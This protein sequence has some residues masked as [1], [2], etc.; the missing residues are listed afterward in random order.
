M[1]PSLAGW[2]ACP[3]VLAYGS[4]LFPMI[5]RMWD[6]RD[7]CLIS[8]PKRARGGGRWPGKGLPCSRGHRGSTWR[9]HRV[10]GGLPHHPELELG[11]MKLGISCHRCLITKVKP[12]R[13]LV[14]DR[15]PRPP[16]PQAAASLVL[17]RPASESSTRLSSRP[18]LCDLRSRGEGDVA[19]GDHRCPGS[20]N[21]KATSGSNKGQVSRGDSSGASAWQASS[22]ARTSSAAS[23]LEAP[24]PQ[25]SVS[26]PGTPWEW[27]RWPRAFKLVADASPWPCSCFR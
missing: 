18:L 2:G 9:P 25:A 20:L 5:P 27:L 1:I 8:S 4:Q 19:I 16:G 15:I 7:S 6:V 10:P 26:P 23:S 3:W 17:P 22:S 21:R 12:A 24:L 14:Q 13:E 11:K